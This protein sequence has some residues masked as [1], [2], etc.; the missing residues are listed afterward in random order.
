MAMYNIQNM[1]HL[2]KLQAS[3]A[4]CITCCVYNNTVVNSGNKLRQ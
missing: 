1:P 2:L 4:E 3:S